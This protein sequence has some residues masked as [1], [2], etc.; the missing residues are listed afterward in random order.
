MN[1]MLKLVMVSKES[2]IWCAIYALIAATVVSA[3]AG[4]RLN[5]WTRLATLVLGLGAIVAL[6]VSQGEFGEDRLISLMVVESTFLILAVT[7]PDW[8]GK[9]TRKLL[10]W[11]RDA[12]S[13]LLGINSDPPSL[14][15]NGGA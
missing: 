6:K 3:V 1:Q 10:G 15:P 8:T 11:A 13:A 14:R 12:V 7:D 2:A 9:V 5:L 4:G